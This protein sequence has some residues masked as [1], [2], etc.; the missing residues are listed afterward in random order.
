MEDYDPLYR[1]QI[2]LLERRYDFVT[3]SEVIEHFFEP[4]REFLLLD[5]LLN[6]GSLLGVMTC[7]LEQ[8]SAFQTWWY[9]KD[10]TH[11]CFY[12]KSTLTWIAG[13][14]NW[15]IDF[16]AANVAIFQKL[17]NGIKTDGGE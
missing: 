15:Q 10:P 14:R 9:P 5:G 4:S 3:C 8:E 12:Q 16:P 13:W 1:P 2:D 7:I 17:T 11:V 6:P